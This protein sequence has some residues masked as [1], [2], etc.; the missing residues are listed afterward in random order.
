MALFGSKS[1][2][3]RKAEDDYDA[4]LTEEHKPLRVDSDGEEAEA[5]TQLPHHEIYALSRSLRRTNLFLKIIIGLLGI[6]IIALLS[7]NIPDKVKDMIKQASCAPDYIIKTP[8]PPRM[9][10]Q[11]PQMSQFTKI[12]NSSPQES[13]L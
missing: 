7:I 13:H 8:V 5:T 1:G 11:T 10:P 2:R 6:T 9:T 12:I 3:N 4:V